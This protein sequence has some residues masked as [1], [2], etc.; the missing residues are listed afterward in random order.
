MEEW[1]DYINATIEITTM[2]VEETYELAPK[3]TRK[4]FALWIKENYPEMLKYMFTRLDNKDI[5]PL[6]YKLAF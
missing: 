3:T 4:E 6:I 5:L 1:V 2:H